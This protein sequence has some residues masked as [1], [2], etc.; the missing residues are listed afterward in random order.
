VRVASL[1]KEIGVE[2][3]IFPSSCSAYGFQED[4]VN[5]N[6]KVNP[7]T[8]YAK[9]NNRAEGD[10]LAMADGKFCVTVIRQATVY[11]L[12]PRMRFDL[13]INGMVRGF[14]KNGK[15]PILRDGKQWRPFVHVR[16][17][18][19]AMIMLLEKNMEDINGE[20]FNIGSNEQNYQVFDLAEKVAGAIG[21]PFEYEWYGAPDFRSYRVNFD[22]ARRE[23]GFSPEY[24]TRKG[25]RE[26]WKAL[27]EGRIDPDDP[28]AITIDWYKKLIKEGVEI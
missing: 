11:G 21:I 12:S 26:I 18:A 3:Y 8:V 4:E 7:L 22:K 16:D 5:E 20:L 9:A 27:Q 17:T 6:S 23:L 14:F 25:A 10:V 15:I 19:K 2:R 24:D 28:Q 1:A 13:A